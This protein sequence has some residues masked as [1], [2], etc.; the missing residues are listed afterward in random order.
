VFGPPAG[1]AAGSPPASAPA[2]SPAAVRHGRSSGVLPT[3]GAAAPT[4][5]SLPATTGAAAT[6]A[7]RTALVE[8]HGKLEQLSYFELLGVGEN[9]AVEEVNGAYMRAVRQFHPDRLAAAGLRELAPSAER[10][11]ARMG[12][13]SSVLRDPK[14]RAEYVA[15]RAGKKTELQ[16]AVSIIDAEKSFQKGEVFLRKGDY[17]RAIESFSEAV[18]VN[19]AEPQYRAYLA[20]TRFD[21]PRARKDVVARESLATLQQILREGERF[22][23]GHYWVGQIWKYLNDMDKAERAFREAIKHDKTLLEAEREVRLLEMRRAKATQARPATQGPATAT[24]QT[25]GLL[26]KLFKR[27][28]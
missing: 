2:P 20:W 23:R 1:T 18:K 8:L 27:D 4:S 7:I 28:E 3:L 13:A 5:S 15:N 12:E 9:A 6:E 10:V 14:R 24:R 11:M 19:S 16:A 22:A 17:G 26:G 25:G 21:D